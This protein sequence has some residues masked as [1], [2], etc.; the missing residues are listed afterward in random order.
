M[1]AAAANTTKHMKN[2]LPLL[3]E[4]LIAQVKDRN[5]EG[6][7]TTLEALLAA[8]KPNPNQRETDAYRTFARVI[9][10]ASQAG[11]IMRIEDVSIQSLL[12]S[13]MMGAEAFGK[14]VQHQRLDLLNQQRRQQAV[15]Q[16]FNT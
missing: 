3:R 8:V 12:L 7:I 13:A 1:S 6:V 15:Y 14:K 16:P 4:A 11:D 9:S 2:A 5:I 10:D